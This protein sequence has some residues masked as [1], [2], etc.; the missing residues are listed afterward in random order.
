[1]DATER[2]RREALAAVEHARRAAGRWLASCE[3]RDECDTIERQRA[4][5]AKRALDDLKSRTVAAA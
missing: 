4:L 2:Q 1:M 3:V 5:R